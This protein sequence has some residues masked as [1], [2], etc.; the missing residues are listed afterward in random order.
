L[1]NYFVGDDPQVV[2]AEVVP[3]AVELRRRSNT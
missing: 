1:F 2:V 3:L